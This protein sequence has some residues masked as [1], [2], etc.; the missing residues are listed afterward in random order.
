MKSKSKGISFTFQLI[1][2]MALGT[3]VGLIFAG[4]AAP[5]GEFARL[6]HPG[7]EDLC[8]RLGGPQGD[9]T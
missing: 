3:G 7:G 4:K 2:A 5:I 1:D 9:C 6:N 8:A